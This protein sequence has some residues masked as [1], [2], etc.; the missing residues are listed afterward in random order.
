MDS[1]LLAH[2]TEFTFLPEGATI[3]EQDVFYFAVRVAQRSNGLWAV[4]RM[5]ECWNRKT[6]DWEYEPRDRSQ[7]FL[8]QCRFT[9]D[10]AVQIARALPD[11]MTI[12]GKSWLDFKAIH[13]LQDSNRR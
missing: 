5:N 10:E 8:R 9:L 3:D 2:A 6:K 13:A 7:T 12:M 1:D 11:T 4:L